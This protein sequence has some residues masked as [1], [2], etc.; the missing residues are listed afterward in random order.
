MLYN[1]E[2]GKGNYEDK[3]Y[4]GEKCC[5]KK[6]EPCKKCDPCCKHDEKEDFCKCFCKC[7]TKRPCKYDSKKEEEYD[8]D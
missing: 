7:M 6:Y 5:E 4:D 3:K 2:Y 8:E 1:Q